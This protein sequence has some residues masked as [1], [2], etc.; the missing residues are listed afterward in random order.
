MAEAVI[1]LF[2]NDG[3]VAIGH[4]EKVACLHMT[5]FQTSLWRPTDASIMEK[6]GEVLPKVKR[7]KR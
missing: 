5:N 4:T 7:K 1:I 2:R 3:T 6:V